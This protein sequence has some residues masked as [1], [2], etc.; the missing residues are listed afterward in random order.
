M[1]EAFSWSKPDGIPGLI[2]RKQVDW[3]MLYE[4]SHIPREFHPDF[5]EANNGALPAEGERVPVTL[6][7]DGAEYPASLNL[8]SR[9]EGQPDLELRFAPQ[10]PQG[11]LFRTVFA[12]SHEVLRQKRSEQPEEGRRRAS[13]SKSDAEYVEF[14]STDRPFRYEL[15]LVPYAAEWAPPSFEEIWSELQAIIDGGRTVRTLSAGAAN[16]VEWRGDRGIEVRTGEREPQLLGKEM[17]RAAWQAL[18]ERR[19]VVT[20]DLP[21][22]S[23]Y[24]STAVQAILALL[25]DVEYSNEPRTTLFLRQSPFP[26]ERLVEAFELDTEGSVR[27]PRRPAAEPR[28]AF[29]FAEESSRNT[30]VGDRFNVE[31]TD[32]VLE[33]AW[34][35][36]QRSITGA[37]TVYVFRRAENGV[38]RYVGRMKLDS[39]SVPFV[40]TLVPMTT[41]TTE[42]RSWIFQASPDSYDLEGATATLPELTWLVSRYANDIKTGD[43]VFLWLSGPKSGVRAHAKVLSDPAMLTANEAEAPYY[44]AAEKFAGEHLRVR[45]RVEKRLQNPITR[46]EMLA[47]PLLSQVT[48]LRMPTGT[49]FPLTPEQAVELRRLVMEPEEEAPDLDLSKVVSEFS[50]ALHKSHIHFGARHEEIV[51]SFVASLATKPFVILTGLSGSGKT[52]IALRFGQWL[53]EGHYLVVPVRPDWTGAEHLFGYEDALQKGPDGRPVWYI[54]EALSF[55]LKAARDP[56]RPYLLVLDEMNLAHVERYFADVLSGMESG[57]GCLPNVKQDGSGIWQ[58]VSGQQMRLPFPRNL[59]VVGTVNVDETTYMFSPKVLDRANTFEFRVSTADLSMEARKPEDCQAGPVPLVRGFLEIACNAGWQID[60]PATGKAEFSQHVRH[61]HALLSEAGF[62]FGHRVF[63]E[64]IRFA[65]MWEAAGDGD[66]LRALDLQIFQKVLP[67]LHGNRKQL[68]ALLSA[69]GQYCASLSYTEGSVLDGSAART[70]PFGAGE[71]AKLPLTFDK[72]RR[73]MRTLKVN[74]F[75][76]FTE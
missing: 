39:R 9:A 40:A 74:G 22:E 53:G 8:R 36:L 29:V 35:V 11:Q 4:G 33:Q 62:E 47:N 68:E 71:T 75:T 72:L 25:P 32:C 65:A 70:N 26:E 31:L 57:E 67:R 5:A 12:Y 50:A 14:Y 61:V 28:V 15:R 3:S 18:A 69:L 60:H 52:Q 54:P 56:G 45:V 6:V 23:R 46:N 44:L 76:S 17:F 51:R 41:A 66:L 63:F 58:P 37:V 20:N 21:R 24:R 1:K 2:A 16:Q 48:F 59:F 49:N 42:E 64:A 19:L 7:L 55:M 43:E 27:W 10:S 13:V 30:W 34:P 73:M 38:C